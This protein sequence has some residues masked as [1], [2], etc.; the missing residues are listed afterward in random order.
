[1]YST[2]E[3]STMTRAQVE[4][5]IQQLDEKYDLEKTIVGY[6]DEIDTL[7]NTFCD[8]NR[9]IEQINIEEGYERAA[10]T[11]RANKQK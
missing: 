10:E 7:V 8:L 11:I 2:E 5:A 9:R 6:T 1:M 4:S 3:I